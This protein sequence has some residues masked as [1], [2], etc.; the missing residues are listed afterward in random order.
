MV[1]VTQFVQG[2]IAAQEEDNTSMHSADDVETQNVADRRGCSDAHIIDLLLG[3]VRSDELRL[4]TSPRRPGN[5]VCSRSNPLGL[6]QHP[7]HRRSLP[8]HVIL[9]IHTTGQHIPAGSYTPA[10]QTL[11]QRHWW[12]GENTFSLVLHYMDADVS[13]VGSAMRGAWAGRR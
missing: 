1:T 13:P 5:P 6:M 11:R 12:G 10:P 3:L 2:Q 7:R 4:R 8:R 9:V